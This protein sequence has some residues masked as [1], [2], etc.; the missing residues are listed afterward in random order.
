MRT[1]RLREAPLASKVS[2]KTVT[3]F[4]IGSVPFLFF[5]G[6]RYTTVT[7]CTSSGSVF[8]FEKKET[9]ARVAAGYPVAVHAA[10]VGGEKGMGYVC[11]LLSSHPFVSLV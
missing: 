10:F 5:S 2:I 8:V 9:A 4:H 1:V 3:G 11:P 7:V 6:A